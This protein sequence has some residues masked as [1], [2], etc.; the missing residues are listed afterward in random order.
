MNLLILESPGKV[1]KVQSFL[2]SD[3]KVVA[4]VGHVRDLPERELGIALPDFTPDYMPTE[5]GKEVLGRLKGLAASASAVYLATDPDREG[6]AIA[7]H[8]ADALRLKNPKR[9]TYG[10]ITAAAIQT[11]IKSPRSLDMALVSAQ[12]AR[13]VLDRFCGY[14]VSGPLSR[15]ANERLSAGRVQSPAVRLVVERERGIR[16]F[17][18][19]THYGAELAFADGWRATWITK[20]WLES[21]QEYLLD[22][23]L[24]ELA[25]AVRSLTV[26]ECKESESRAA[27]PAPFTTSSLQQAASNA[28]K[29]TPKQTMQLAQKLYEGGHITYMR[30]DSPNLSAEAVVEIRA[31]C[32]AQGLPLVDK[33]RTWKSK[34]GAQEAHEAVRPT[35][36]DVE[37]AGDTPD[38]Q[39]LY[40]LIRLRTLAS[41][42]A[43]AVYD[44][45]TVRLSAAMQGKTALFEARGRVLREPG[46]KVLTATDSATQ[47]E[48]GEADAPDNP[49]PMLPQGE[50]VTAAS[51]KLL[52]KK[53]KPPTR[54]SEASLVR[55]LENRGIGRPATFAAIVDTIMKREY[56]RAEK[57]Q[58]V[59]TPLGE[60]VVDFLSGAF[61]FLDYEF[62]R[63]MEDSLDAIAGGKAAYKE[64]MH[65][66]HARLVSEVT[67]FTAKYPGQERQ[68]PEL[69]DFTCTAC[70]KPLVHMKGQRRDGSGTYDFFA[71]SDRACNTS[72]ANADG[73]PGDARKKAELSK[74]KCKACGKALVRRDSAK[75]PFFGCSGYPGCKQ[76]YH[77][78]DDGK[79]DFGSKKGGK[80]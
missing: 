16:N 66:A 10:E 15:A 77:V 26:Q 30:T 73:K 72:Y 9:V 43:D 78:G 45:R 19:V 56:V 6:E 59:P 57:R 67:A 51:G 1:K 71:C 37:E 29:F 61:T 31:F 33:P 47:D 4:S 60:K 27:P 52:T 54:F 39:A 70:G 7:W 55:E 41:Q 24:A 25:A 40:R 17:V 2:G 68:A 58:L 75:G 12:E 8:I 28:L 22:K 49:V 38:E 44:V 65:K 48:D 35:H 80:K 74:F 18:A 13:R 21:G 42:L 69:T 64:V 11:A 79:P 53:T 14:L 62:T 32:E 34:D 46:W 5:R 3:W 20:P 50:N 36:I 23:G 63:M 76:L